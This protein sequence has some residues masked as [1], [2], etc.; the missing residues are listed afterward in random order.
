[1]NNHLSK[2][3]QFAKIEC[4]FRHVDLMVKIAFWLRI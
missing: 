3:Q 2:L 4:R 1:V